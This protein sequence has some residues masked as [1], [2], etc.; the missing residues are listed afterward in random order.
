MIAASEKPHLPKEDIKVIIRPK[1]GFNTAG[2]S[3]AQIGDCIL[4][5]IGLKSEE[6]VKDSIRINERQNIVVI[7]KILKQLTPPGTVKLTAFKRFT[8]GSNVSPFASTNLSDLD[9]SSCRSSCHALHHKPPLQA[10]SG[11]CDWTF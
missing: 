4:R 9:F 7:N 3:V 5:A 2:C 6:V 8:S 10:R 1:D 11:Y